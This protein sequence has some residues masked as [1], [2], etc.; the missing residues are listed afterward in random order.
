MTQ[1]MIVKDGKLVDNTNW[2]TK[3]RLVKFIYDEFC[4]RFAESSEEDRQ[5]G[6]VKFYGIGMSISAHGLADHQLVLLKEVYENKDT[7]EQILYQKQVRISN[8]GK[9]INTNFVNPDKEQ[10]PNCG[11]KIK[12]VFMDAHI[13]KY[14]SEP[15]VLSDSYL[16][17]P[18]F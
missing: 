1:S 15:S 2:A 18:E 14:C 9:L 13:E 12:K 17:D 4:K 7:A 10:C 8:D 16:D 6:K 3:R 5:N 11:K